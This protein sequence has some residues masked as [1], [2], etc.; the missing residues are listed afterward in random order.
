MIIIDF[1]ILSYYILF[2]RAK[3]NQLR[4]SII[5]ASQL[6]ILFIVVYLLFFFF[7]EMIHIEGNIQS[8]LFFGATFIVVGVTLNHVLLKH[9]LKQKERLDA[10]CERFDKYRYFSI[11]LF[12]FYFF[13]SIFLLF[14]SMKLFG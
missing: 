12:L 6:P 3:Q 5:L 9:Y 8:S 13:L 11:V 1:I 14:D 4:G 2:R 7:G 10:I